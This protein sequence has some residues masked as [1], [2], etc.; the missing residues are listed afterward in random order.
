MSIANLFEG[1]CFCWH[2]AGYEESGATGCLF[3]DPQP[4]L[5]PPPAPPPSSSNWHACARPLLSRQ[6]A[7]MRGSRQ[8]GGVGCV[9]DSERGG[10][11]AGLFG[12]RAGRRALWAMLCVSVSIHSRRGAL[13]VLPR[14][15]CQTPLP[16]PSMLPPRGQPVEWRTSLPGCPRTCVSHTH[17]HTHRLTS[18]HIDQSVAGTCFCF[19]VLAFPNATLWSRTREIPVSTGTE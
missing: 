10:L 3:A 14:T 16:P 15:C 19:G 6:C 7:R 4:K 1:F 5:A 2:R 8:A 12:F 9:C 13:S 18:T 11:N 17:T